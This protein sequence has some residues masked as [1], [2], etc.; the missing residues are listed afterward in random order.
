MLVLPKGNDNMIDYTK[1]PQKVQHIAMGVQR[2]LFDQLILTSKHV[3]FNEDDT[4]GAFYKYADPANQGFKVYVLSDIKL[5]PDS[6]SRFY[7]ECEYP[8]P[9]GPVGKLKKCFLVLKS[10]G[11]S[12]TFGGYSVIEIREKSPLPR[13]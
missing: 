11:D 7:I 1:A 2:G 3:K 4:E 12:K 10:A 6:A 13:K 9:K 5:V 8:D